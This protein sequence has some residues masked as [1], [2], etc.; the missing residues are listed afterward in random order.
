MDGDEGAEEGAEESVR[1]SVWGWR[2]DRGIAI[3]IEHMYP[4]PSLQLG[5]RWYAV[6]HYYLR[7]LGSGVA[8]ECIE[9]D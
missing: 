3:S 7:V 6:L 1:V 4:A 9:L 5:R 2:R 8:A